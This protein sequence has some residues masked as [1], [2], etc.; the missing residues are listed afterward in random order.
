MSPSLLA[1]ELNPVHPSELW[2]SSGTVPLTMSQ[3]N[4]LA[5]PRFSQVQ[6]QPAV[7]FPRKV[8]ADVDTIPTKRQ[9]L[10]RNAS[11]C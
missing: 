6:K 8:P 5:L 10:S 7:F 3:L 9:Q 11:F 4:H 1:A 2:D